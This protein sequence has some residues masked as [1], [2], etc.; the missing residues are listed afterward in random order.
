MDTVSHGAWTSL[1]TYHHPK[2]W[3]IVLGAVFPDAAIIS[4]G[5]SMFLQGKLT[6]TPPW[7]PKLYNSSITPLLDSMFHSIVLWAAVLGI[8]ILLKVDTLRM[9][10]YGIFFHIGI[11]VV[12]HKMFVPKY[13]F[14]LS[15]VDIIGVIDYRT[16]RFT[17]TDFVL[18]LV[19]LGVY[20][21]NRYR[22]R[23]KR[24]DNL[25]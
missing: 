13:F 12:T 11:D 4:I 24:P 8:S 22:A 14:P 6:L 20:L 23:E 15:R 10:A 7:L 16:L 2:R 9:F 17:L 18:L 1:I 5:F 19:S 25:L 21:W 3:F